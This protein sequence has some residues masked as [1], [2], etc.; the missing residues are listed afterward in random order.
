MVKKPQQNLYFSLL[1]SFSDEANYCENP[2]E[3]VSRADPWRDQGRCNS[4]QVNFI[5]QFNELNA[6]VYCILVALI[7]LEA[8]LA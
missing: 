4:E 1:G 7:N 2:K 6:H 8:P 5:N 3:G